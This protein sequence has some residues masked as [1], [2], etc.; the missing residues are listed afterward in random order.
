MGDPIWPVSESEERADPL[1]IDGHDLDRGKRC[2]LRI[3]SAMI[4]MPV[5]MRDQQRKLFAVLIRQQLEDRFRQRHCFRV[6]D[7]A[8]IN[9]KSF[10]GA[11]E[12]IDKICFKV[13]AWTLAQDKRL[14]FVLMN[15]KGFLRSCTA[16]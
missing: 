12:E 3:A 2:K 5:G 16:I 9:Q 13:C 11:D 15:L 8:S 6:G 1:Q 14:R 10:V 4:Q 7:G